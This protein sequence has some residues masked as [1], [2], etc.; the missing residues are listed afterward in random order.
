M[1]K[2]AIERQAEK[3]MKL[4]HRAEVVKSVGS[5]RNFRGALVR[6]GTYLAENGHKDFRSVTKEVAI[7]YLETRAQEV[8]QSSLNMDRQALQH[9]MRHVTKQLEPE[10]ALTVV[11]S[12]L[13]QALASRNY[14]DQQ[15]DLIAQRQAEHNQLATQIAHAAGL[16]AHELLTLRR[17]SERG[18]DKRERSDKKFLGR[19]GQIYTVK[20]KGGLVR[21]VLIPDHLAAKLEAVR[22]P[23][24]VTIKDRE[25]IYQS[26]YRI[27]GGNGWSQSYSKTSRTALGWSRGGHGLRYS[28]AQSRMKELRNNGVYY[29][30]AQKVVSQEMGHFRPEIT[31]VYLR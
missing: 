10:E 22:L 16:R 24:P 29:E 2:K 20:G 3:L 7:F 30:E 25:V 15:K 26:F 8:K 31:E 12:E 6:I 19:E 27:G 17:I 4:L 5:S 9:V 28:Y 18:P 11:K 13:D 23:E 21:E 1:R 14:T